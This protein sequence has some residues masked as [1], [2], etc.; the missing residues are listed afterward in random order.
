MFFVCR[1]CWNTHTCMCSVCG[2]KNIWGKKGQKLF[3][4]P[5]NLQTMF[6]S[7]NSAAA[8]NSKMWMTHLA[9]LHT[10]LTIEPNYLDKE[11]LKQEQCSHLLCCKWLFTRWPAASADMSESS[12]ASTVPH[13]MRANLLA[14]SPGHSLFAP[15][16]MHLWVIWSNT[17][18]IHTPM[19]RAVLL[20]D[21]YT[22]NSMKQDIAENYWTV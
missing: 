8:D 22:N 3:E 6:Y 14:F 13:T 9:T 11:L 5:W 20:I 12:P 2:I 16:M 17:L 4:I 10:Q 19:N 18:L 15:A 7:D 21:S 1:R